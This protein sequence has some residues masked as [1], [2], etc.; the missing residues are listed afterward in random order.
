MVHGPCGK[1]KPNAQCMYNQ[2]GEVTE[3]CHKSFPKEFSNDTVWDSNYSYAKYRRRSPD[4]GGSDAFCNDK[5][6]DNSWIV[7]YSPYLLLKYNCHLNTEICVSPKATKYLYK[8]VNK[9]GDRAMVRVD[10]GVDNRGRNE[11]REYQDLRSIGASEACWRLFKFEM[12]DRYVIL[13]RAYKNKFDSILK[14]SKVR[15]IE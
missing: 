7:P 9:G 6:L 13:K 1:T 8:Y 14:N 4:N 5:I 10:G 15:Q 12:S 3:I 2:N 11:I